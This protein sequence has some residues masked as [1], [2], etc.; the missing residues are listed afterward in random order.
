MASH[1][2]YVGLLSLTSFLKTL[3]K[4]FA[5]FI[6][7]VVSVLEVWFITCLLI[8]EFPESFWYHFCREPFSFE[9]TSE[10]FLFYA[11][12]ILNENFVR[13]LK[14]DINIIFLINQ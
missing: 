4:W 5:S 11:K 13:I 9:V 14:D 8:F 3:G 6:L 12:I 2:I 7:E 1:T 10:F